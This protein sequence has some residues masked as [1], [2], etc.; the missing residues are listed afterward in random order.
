[1]KKSKV[2]TYLSRFSASE[3][4]KFE[5]FVASPYFNQKQELVHLMGYLIPFHPDFPEENVKKASIIEKVAFNKKNNEKELSYQMSYLFKLIEQFLAISKFENDER[6]KEV[7]LIESLYEKKL[8]SSFNT[9]LSK[10]LQY[11]ENVEDKDAQHYLNAALLYDLHS[12]SKLQR[13]HDDSLQKA[14]DYND[15]YFFLNKLKYSVSMLDRSSFLEVDYEIEFLD[16]TTSYLRNSKFGKEPIIA[17]Y[18]NILDIV[19]EIDAPEKFKKLKAQ[20]F[21]FSSLISFKE[22]KDIYI[23]GINYC[24]RQIKKNEVAYLQEAFDLYREGIR[25]GFLLDDNKEI[26]YW[27]YIN[28]TKLGVR[29]KEFDLTREFIFDNKEKIPKKFRND[30]FNYNLS[31]LNYHTKNYDEVQRL[32]NNIKVNDSYIHAMSRITLCKIYF[33]TYDVEPLLSLIASFS[34]FL[35]RDKK[36]AGNMKTFYKNFCDALFQLLKRNPKKLP[37]V[38]EKIKTVES[39]SDREWLL[40]AAEKIQTEKRWRV[41]S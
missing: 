25:K 3:I 23:A 35:K 39:I 37:K 11:I 38:I 24:A 15:C 27:T 14:S 31:E 19:R 36:L 1:M 7:K 29:L 10:K 41:P 21:S 5:Q 28:V 34:I 17:V 16:E 26:T 2:L 40:Q 20:I 22:F 13:K 18:L 33:E 6:L 8:I 30:A 9:E 32:I 4:Q 12:Q